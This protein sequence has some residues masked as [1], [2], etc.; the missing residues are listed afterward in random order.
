MIVMRSSFFFVFFF[1]TSIFGISIQLCCRYVCGVRWC[2]WRTQ[3]HILSQIN[4]ILN[5]NHLAERHNTIAFRFGK[6]Y[7]LTLTNEKAKR[8][9]TT[10][11]T[12]KP[13][14][15]RYNTHA[16][17]RFD[18]TMPFACA[19]SIGVCFYYCYLFTSFHV[20]LLHVRRMAYLYVYSE[21]YLLRSHNSP[22]NW[23]IERYV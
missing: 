5:D 13:S 19:R 16:S 12:V 14:Q 15:Q 23:S 9:H 18:V 1:L 6:D 2:W 3:S 10:V 22:F 4:R 20:R 7:T 11:P 17:F 21:Y 8:T